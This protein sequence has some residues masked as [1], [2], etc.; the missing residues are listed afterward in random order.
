MTSGPVSFDTLP[1]LLILVLSIVNIICNQTTHDV[2]IMLEIYSY[3]PGTMQCYDLINPINAQ[4]KI[5]K[6]FCISNPGPCPYGYV[7]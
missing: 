5:N 4:C 7:M 6:T 1:R 3:L 2:P